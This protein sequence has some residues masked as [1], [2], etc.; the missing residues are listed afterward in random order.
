MIEWL[1]NSLGSLAARIPAVGSDRRKSEDDALR[2]ISV[3]LNKTYLYYRDIENGGAPN[4][5]TEARLSKLWADAAIP[6]RHLDPSLAAACEH[7][8]QYWL[9]PTDWSPRR[10][11]SF[12]I[13]LDE[14]RHKYRRLL[15]PKRV[16]PP[17]GRGRP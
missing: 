12:G 9:S 6:L 16:G 17:L 13:G 15:T 7:K 4:P 14:M 8:A 11:R 1:L 2:A 5:R 3:A 10:I